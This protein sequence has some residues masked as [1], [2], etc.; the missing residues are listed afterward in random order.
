M[1]NMVK[2]KRKYISPTSELVTLLTKYETLEE[3][4]FYLGNSKQKATVQG[5]KGNYQQFDEEEETEI[6]GTK[7]E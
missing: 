6:F 1:N 7:W 2:Y 5:A 3:K 4:D